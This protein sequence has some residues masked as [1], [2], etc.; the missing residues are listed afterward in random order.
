MKLSE[1]LMLGST[2]GTKVDPWDYNACFLG[3]ACHAMGR[4]NITLKESIDRWPW[5]LEYFRHPA[6]PEEI[7]QGEYIVSDLCFMVCDERLTLEEAV[8]CIRKIEPQDIQGEQTDE[9]QETRIAVLE[10]TEA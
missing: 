5:L 3:I 4:E 7:R 10:A 1:A 8:D 6:K 2:L 9:V